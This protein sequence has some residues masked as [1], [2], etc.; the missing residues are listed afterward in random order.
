MVKKVGDYWSGLAHWILEQAVDNEQE[1]CLSAGTLEIGKLRSCI[2]WM[3]VTAGDVAALDVPD[4]SS[5]GLRTPS[6]SPRRTLLVLL[7]MLNRLSLLA[8]HIPTHSHRSLSLSSPATTPISTTMSITKPYQDIL[9]RLPQK[10]QSAKQ[11]GELLFFDSET[12]EV[13]TNGRKVCLSSFSRSCPSWG[14]KR[15]EI[16]VYFF[17]KGFA[18]E[19]RTYIVRSQDLSSVSE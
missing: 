5:R 2:R 3:L 17:W 16:G 7:Y 12:K 11:C 13:V 14:E 1:D 19:K 18:D 4:D 15:N 9:D 6:S 10:F 8:R